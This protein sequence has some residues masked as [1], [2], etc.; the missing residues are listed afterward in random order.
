M[1]TLQRVQKGRANKRQKKRKKKKIL[2]PKGKKTDK[3]HGKL[4]D[5]A[6]QGER[7]FEEFS[8]KFG[9]IKRRRT[10]NRKGGKVGPRGG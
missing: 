8:R 5:S 6:G 4:D 10:S 9:G 2:V 1:L 7:P 3:S